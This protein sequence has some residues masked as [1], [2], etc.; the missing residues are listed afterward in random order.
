[1]T[2]ITMWRIAAS[3]ARDAPRKASA[4]GRVS[5]IG[6]DPRELGN[7]GRHACIRI[8]AQSKRVE[9][10][11]AGVQEGGQRTNPDLCAP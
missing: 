7:D 10:G 6:V 9:S 5:F 4:S 1:V 2:F 8:G 11:D 3:A